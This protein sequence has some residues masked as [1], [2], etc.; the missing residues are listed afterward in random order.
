MKFDFTQEHLQVIA[1]A[2]GKQPYRKV[3]P[4]IHEIQ[5]QISDQQSATAGS[6]AE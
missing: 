5:R 4:V 2:L 6:T 3:A 1:D